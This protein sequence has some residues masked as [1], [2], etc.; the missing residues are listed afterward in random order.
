MSIQ[1]NC[2]PYNKSEFGRRH[3]GR[4]DHMKTQGE[5]GQPQAKREEPQNGI[6]PVNVWI[7]GFQPQNR[8]KISKL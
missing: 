3:A 4:T 8:E 1:Y 6:N 5:D 2:C 7:S